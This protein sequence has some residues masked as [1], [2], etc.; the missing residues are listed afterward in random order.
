MDFSTSVL[1]FVA[2]NLPAAGRSFTLGNISPC[3]K[4]NKTICKGWSLDVN[5]APSLGVKFPF[6]TFLPWMVVQRRMFQWNVCV[7]ICVWCWKEK[8]KQCWNDDP[9]ISPGATSALVEWPAL[10][11]KS[12]VRHSWSIPPAFITLSKTLP[13]TPPPQAPVACTSPPPLKISEAESRNVQNVCCETC[14]S[15]SAILSSLPPSL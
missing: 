1:Y 15:Q 12:P 11:K 3:K 14:Q 6:Q 13:Q 7:W 2:F 5:P 8:G 9:V 4:V 10:K